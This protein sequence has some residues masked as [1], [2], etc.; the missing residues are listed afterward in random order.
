MKINRVILGL[1][2]MLLF[3]LPAHTEVT[4][5]WKDVYI[6]ALD[7]AGWAGLVLAPTRESGFA[8]RIK[9]IK[10]EEAA[11]GID[12]L[13]LIS[14]VGPHSPDGRYA[15]IKFDL[16]L[17]FGKGEDTP[18]LK[19]PASKSE[20]MQM[21]WSRQDE[22]TVIGRIHIPKQTKIQLVFYS[23]WDT[24]GRYMIQEDSHIIGESLGLSGSRFLFWTN[25]PGDLIA[26]N[27]NEEV[28]LAF[29]SEESQDIYFVAGVGSDAKL[30]SNRIYRY[31]N[32][33][34]ILSFLA[35]EARIYQQNR[36]Q[37]IGPIRGSAAS[38]TNNLFWSSLYQPGQHRFY[39]PS[40]RDRIF[41]RP[42]GSPHPWTLYSWDSFFNGMVL[43][44][45]STKHAIDMIKAALETQYPNGNIPH[46]RAGAEGSP[47]RSQPPVGGYVVL[48][49]F[50]KTGDVEL[51]RFAYPY[52]TR[53]HAF[54]KSKRSN[55]LVR[56]DGNGDGLLE[57]GSDPEL[58]RGT[59]PDW[60]DSDSGKE[61]AQYESGMPDLPNWDMAG[62]DRLTGTLTMNCLDLNCLYALDAW[63]LAQMAGVLNQTEDNRSYTDEY[64][65]IKQLINDTFWNSREGFYFDRHWDGRF[66]EKK[67]AS[68]FYPLLA[69]IPDEDRARQLRR[70]LLDRSEF[71]GDY[72]IP[73]VSRESDE[74]QDQQN[75]RGAVWAPSNYLVYQ[76]LK[77]YGFDVEAHEFA[78]KS[79]DL[80]LLTWKNFQLCPENFDSRTGEATGRRFQSWGPLMALIALEEYID[81]T[82]WEGFRFG[83][84]QPEKK[85]E[86]KGIAIQGRQYDIRASSGEIRLIEDGREIIRSKGG[87]IFRR[88]LYNEQEVS[89][90]VMVLTSR[91]IRVRFLIKGKYQYF[92]DNQL[93]NVFEGDSAEIVVPEGRHD[94]D[95]ILVEKAR[96]PLS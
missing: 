42:N 74:F 17:P 61:R 91:K 35:E 1:L 53:W 26:E 67:S 4:Y 65:S 72:V 82:P 80:F 66:S 19:K 92:L 3:C 58:V 70:H 75:W 54:W 15:R 52:L 8:F 48:K 16:S 11:E 25:R 9:I 77:A 69:R 32:E 12:F 39:T 87:A 71:W 95:I 40:G 83:V 31:K 10:R 94:V 96:S 57:W 14:E 89:F 93:K 47:D 86:I 21:E 81:I 79:V 5:P 23:P 36:V 7:S 6:G 51:L 2:G 37:A 64:D 59:D 38:V 68:N 85:T 88:F 29:S 56:R 22:G 90:E 62:F 49:L 73:T 44:L 43:S 13:Y 55:G 34:T 60:M 84:L 76:G 30:L 46:W 24:Q 18:I 45:E 41:L 63:C 33:K 20:A 28:A 78:K 27:Q 50:Q